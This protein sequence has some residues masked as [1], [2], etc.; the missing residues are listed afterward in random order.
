MDIQSVPFMTV[1][2]MPLDEIKLAPF[3]PSMRTTGQSLHDMLNDIRE[4]GVMYPVSLSRDGFLGD[5]HRRVACAK[6]I[7]LKSIPA[8]RFDKSVEQLFRLNG[9]QRPVTDRDWVQVWVSGNHDVPNKNSKRIGRVIEIV[10]EAGMQ[11]LAAKQ[12]G[13]SM[14]DVTRMIVNYCEKDEPEFIHKT[15]WWLL[16]TGQQFAARSAMRTGVSPDIL[17]D[18]VLNNRHIIRE[19]K[20]G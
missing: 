10:G 7:G 18:A 19:W 4:Q 6:I 1:F 15:F 2:E 11:A 16:N 8:M 14:L 3:N 13:T 12:R 20:S 17:E 5:G 9:I